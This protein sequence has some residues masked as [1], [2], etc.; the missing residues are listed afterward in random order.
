MLASNGGSLDRFERLKLWEL[1]SAFCTEDM[2]MSSD[3]PLAAVPGY[4]DFSEGSYG[5]QPGRLTLDHGI[6][7]DQRR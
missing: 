4:L 3:L 5:L 1:Y 7:V 6:W 2:G